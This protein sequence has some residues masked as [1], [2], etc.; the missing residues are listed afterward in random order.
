[1]EFL[2]I[3]E[4][5]KFDK[6]PS[7]AMNYNGYVIE[8][9]IEGYTTLNVFGREKVEY[10][11][12]TV[13]NISGRDGEAFLDKTLAPRSIEVQFELIGN[14]PEELQNKLYDLVNLLHS[15]GEIEIRFKD[16]YDKVYYGQFESL[17]HVPGDRLTIIST[18][19][20]RCSDPHK[21]SYNARKLVGNPINVFVRNVYNVVPDLIRVYIS[22]NRSKLIVRNRNTSKRIILNGTFKVDDLI[23]IN[24]NNKSIS[25]N[26]QSIIAQLDYRES[27]F[28]K[29]VLNSNDIIDTDV[30]NDDLEIT[31]RSRWK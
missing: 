11:F 22:S 31:I 4:Y 28:K 13:D 29:F 26:G 18:I 19:T 2:D 15:D 8:N 21:Y 3:N 17:T 7:V 23:V 9:E 20:I 1:M 6:L 24:I 16:E 10:R 27:D 12:N 5:G 30:L 14:S 25:Q